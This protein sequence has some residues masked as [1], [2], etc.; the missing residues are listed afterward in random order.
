M[1]GECRYVDIS[2]NKQRSFMGAK[3]W[4]LID[5]D[6]KDYCWSFV[7]KNKLDLKGKIKTWLSGL[8]ISG[9]NVRFIRCDETGK[10]M[11]IKNDPEFNLFGFKFEFLF[12]ELLKVMER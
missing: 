2:S 9:L 5:D 4:A 3:F 7:K 1:P 8:K 12:L 6:C 11:T 10:I